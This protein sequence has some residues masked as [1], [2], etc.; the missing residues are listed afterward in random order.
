MNSRSPME[1]SYGSTMNQLKG[2]ANGFFGKGRSLTGFLTPQDSG[3]SSKIIVPQELIPHL[4][5]LQTRD[6]MNFLDAQK[7]PTTESS[8]QYCAW[9][10]MSMRYFDAFMGL[11]ILANLFAMVF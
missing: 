5:R 1:A 11:V 9:R 7:T 3:S 10:I 8:L 4:K 6:I 2:K